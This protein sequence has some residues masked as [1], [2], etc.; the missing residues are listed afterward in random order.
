MLYQL[1][2][3]I[4]QQKKGRSSYHL[5]ICFQVMIKKIPEAWDIYQALGENVVWFSGK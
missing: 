5:Q 4:T 3:H 2:F 1:F